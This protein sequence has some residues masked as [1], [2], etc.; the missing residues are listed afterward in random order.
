MVQTAIP[1]QPRDVQISEIGMNTQV[2][3]SRTWEQLKF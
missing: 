3:R 2:L 1:T